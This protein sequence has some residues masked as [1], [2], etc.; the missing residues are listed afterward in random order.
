MKKKILL[1]LVLLAILFG[2]CGNTAQGNSYYINPSIDYDRVATQSELQ[3]QQ[4]QFEQF[5]KE[6]KTNKFTEIVVDDYTTQD[7]TIRDKDLIKRW[8]DLFS[9]MDVEACTYDM[10]LGGGEL[11]KFKIGDKVIYTILVCGDM[12]YFSHDRT[13]IYVRNYDELYQTVVQLKKDSGIA[14]SEY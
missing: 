12:I 9:E 6:L 2:G 7:K 13:M 4:K 5:V 1:A 14:S 8:V 3:A 10:T 11:M